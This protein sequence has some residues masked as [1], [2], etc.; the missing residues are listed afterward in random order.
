MQNSLA[1]SYMAKFVQPIPG[2]SGGPGCKL[3]A[4]RVVFFNT[5]AGA[6]EG[7]M[8]EI[9]YSNC[10]AFKCAGNGSFE[11]PNTICG[12]EKCSLNN[13]AASSEKGLCFAKNKIRSIVP[14][15]AINKFFHEYRMCEELFY[16]KSNFYAHLS[17]I[18][19]IFQRGKG[20]SK[21]RRLCA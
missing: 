1:P 19:R 5:S 17:P 8:Y 11:S 6:I 12:S 9:T 18:K 15:G 16:F 3:I 10:W 14:S 7:E 21:S 4:A 13:C 20:L 2:Y